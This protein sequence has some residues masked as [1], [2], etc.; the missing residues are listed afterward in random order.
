MEPKSVFERVK[1]SLEAKNIRAPHYMLIALI[2]VITSLAVL[3]Y[4]SNYVY[5]VMIDDREIGVV[6]DASDVELFVDDLTERCGELYG[7]HIKPGKKIA[8]IKEFRPESETQT[9]TVQQTIR[10]SLG[11]L[12]DAKILLING[13][14][15]LALPED[16]ELD[17]LITS[18][19]AA[20]SRNQGNVTTLESIVTDELTLE[21]AR[22]EPSEVSTVE[23]AVAYLASSNSGKPMQA[24]S[25]TGTTNRGSFFSRYS[26]NLSSPT[27]SGFIPNEYVQDTSQSIE[28]AFVNVRTLEELTVREP[29]PFATEVEYDEEMWIVQKDVLEEGRDGT[30]EITYHITRESG[31]E[32][33]RSKV[34][35]KVVEE[36]VT[37]LEVHGTA[38][39]P[40]IGSGRFIWPV[41]DG[42]EITPGRGFSEWHTG[43][44]IAADLGR[45][46]LAA[47]SGVVWFSGRGG[48]QGNYIIIY[49]GSYWTLYLHNEVNLVNKGDQVEKGEVIG[50]VGSTG[51]SSGP[52]LHFEIRMDD[53]T[54]EWLGYYQH[55][56][57]DPLRF[58]NP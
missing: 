5:V 19:A 51:R 15:A 55:K 47:D 14:P 21:S 48:S 52:H 43:I 28:P 25:L 58:F 54:G 27:H 6:Q 2:C 37:Q 50:R 9:E 45:N 16:C 18:L 26:G 12:T 41:E 38:Q 30:K 4:S 31:V 1:L 29:I 56:P 49:H 39:V 10:S 24:S 35:E 36:P 13:T 42:G 57:I 7:M 32:V 40:N 3:E 33:A 20:Y 44:D 34:G 11:L 46:I 23:E 22:V 8:L 17:L 53:G